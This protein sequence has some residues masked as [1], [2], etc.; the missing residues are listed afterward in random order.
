MRATGLRRATNEQRAAVPQY[1][2]P[3]GDTARSLGG[4]VQ[5]PIAR[6]IDQGNLPSCVG[7]AMCAGAEA[8][9]GI[10]P[11]L[12]W[13]R[14]WT[15][16]RRRDG[17][18]ADPDNGT[19]FSSAIESVTK[20]GLDP[21]EDGEWNRV[22]EMTEPDDLASELAA[23]DR[24][25]VGTERWRAPAG[26]LDAVE[27]A[28]S[29]GLVVAIGTGVKTPYFDFFNRKRS[30]NDVDVVLTNSALG[31][32][33]NGHEQRV[34][35]VEHDS[36]QRRTWVIQNSWGPYG[37]CH[38]PDGSFALGCAK[39]DDSVMRYTWDTDVIRVVSQ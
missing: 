39:V 20:R 14:I 8:V 30:P 12:S 27:D 31:G 22:E 2:G 7:C 1:T 28:L 3:R 11:R 32:Y 18:L 5:Q 37:G 13:V 29:R 15:D 33:S 4:Y 34:I 35:A 24:R 23:Y 17:S 16:A 6:I 19:W 38:L 21:E 26:D 25:Q 9:L 10:P 36:A